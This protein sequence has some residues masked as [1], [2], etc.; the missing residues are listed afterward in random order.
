VLSGVKEFL[1]LVT[2]EKEEKKKARK[3]CFRAKKDQT[4]ENHKGERQ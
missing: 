2:A 4:N 1:F 3:E